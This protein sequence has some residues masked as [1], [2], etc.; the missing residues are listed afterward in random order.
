MTH[1][2]TNLCMRD[3]SCAKVCPVEC[4]QPGTPVE[5]RPT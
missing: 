2:I 5:R 3:N 4:I 1:V